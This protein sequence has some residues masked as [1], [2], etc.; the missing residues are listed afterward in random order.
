MKGDIEIDTG[1]KEKIS[2]NKGDLALVTR[3]EQE[4]LQSLKFIVAAKK[5]LKS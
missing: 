4:I 2:L 5:N 1:L 3:T